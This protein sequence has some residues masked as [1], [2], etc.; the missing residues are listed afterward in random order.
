MAT[1]QLNIEGM[2]WGY[3]AV[4]RVK[5][6]IEI[7]FAQILKKQSISQTTTKNLTKKQVQWAR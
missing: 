4:Q 5:A 3:P 7:Y 2:W 6:R 1:N